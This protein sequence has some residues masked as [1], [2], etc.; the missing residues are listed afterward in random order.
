VE[1]GSRDFAASTPP[2]EGG[3]LLPLLVSAGL[4]AII[5]VGVFG[6]RFYNRWRK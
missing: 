4:A 5:V 3:M 1:G 6:S 2:E